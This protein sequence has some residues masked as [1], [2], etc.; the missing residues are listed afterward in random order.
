VIPPH[1]GD[2]IGFEHTYAVQRAAIEDHPF[3]A[4]VIGGRGPQSSAAVER[5]GWCRRLVRPFDQGSVGA[6]F[7]A[8]VHGHPPRLLVVGDVVERVGHAERLE[9]PLAEV[10]FEGAA[11][12]LLDQASQPVDARSVQPLRS[13]LEEKRPGRVG[14][15][16]PRLE[17]SNDRAR[18]PVTEAR[19]VREQLTDCDRV[20][21]GPK[22]IGAARG[23]ERLEDFQATD[24]TGLVIDAIR[25]SASAVIGRCCPTSA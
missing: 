22:L 11:G 17:I 18:E 4:H 5:G 21:G 25:K 15:T 13:R 8:A 10:V 6:A 9:D 3:E 14:L 2:C 1:Q 23:V 7:N 16:R 24:V 19:G 20:R 12:N